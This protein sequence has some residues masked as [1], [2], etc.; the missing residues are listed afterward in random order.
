[1]E[2]DQRPEYLFRLPD[3]RYIYV[4]ATRGCMSDRSPSL[5]LFIGTGDA[6]E[7][8]PVR[9]TWREIWGNTSVATEKGMLDVPDSSSLTWEEKQGRDFTPTWEETKLE[10]L[11]IK[12]FNI[13]QSAEGV[14]ISPKA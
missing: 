1:M 9:N 6:M 5:K 7:E 8:V 12:D 2:S 11:A 10:T 14:S 3:G 4:S 13:S